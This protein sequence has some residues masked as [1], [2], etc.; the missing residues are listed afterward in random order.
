M[1]Y[2]YILYYTLWTRKSAFY[3][4]FGQPRLR[5]HLAGQDEQALQA[6]AEA[7]RLFDRLTEAASELMDLGF[8]D[9]YQQSRGEVEASIGECALCWPSN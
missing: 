9:I 6:Q 3:G 4:H 7:R 5:L 8:E 1:G 2:K